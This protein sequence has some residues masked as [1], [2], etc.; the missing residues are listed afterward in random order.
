MSE[1]IE[2][3]H[4]AKLARQSIEPGL[5]VDSRGSPVSAGSCL[6][7]ALIFMILLKRYGQGVP[8]VR[9]GADGARD[10]AGQWRGHYWVEVLMPSGDSFVVDVTAD[11]FGHPPLVVRPLKDANKYYRPGPQAEVDSALLDLA[12]EME[13]LDLIAS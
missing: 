13:C 9:G 10:L 8:A 11:Q 3:F 6:H 12:K 1:A 7:A 2:L 5:A 4:L